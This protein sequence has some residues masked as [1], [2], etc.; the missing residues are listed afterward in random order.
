M[1]RG[2]GTLDQHGNWAF[3]MRAFTKTEKAAKYGLFLL[4]C[5][6]GA[7]YV[8]FIVSFPVVVV[9]LLQQPLFSIL[10]TIGIIFA[11]TVIGYALGILDTRLQDALAQY[12]FAFRFDYIPVFSALIFNWRQSDIDSVKG[13]TVIDQAYES[14]YN[15]GNDGIE[16]IVD[17]TFQVIRNSI[18]VVVVAA[19]LG[20]FNPWLIVIVLAINIAEYGLQRVANRWFARHKAE[21]NQI[22]SYQSYFTRLLLKRSSGKDIRLFNMLPLLHHHLLTLG[23]GVVN[24]QRRYS[25]V[26]TAVGIAQVA[27]NALGML[28]TLLFLIQSQTVSIE[29]IIVFIT[30]MQVLNTRFTTIR[31]AY[32]EIGRNLSYATN[33]RAFLG[34]AQPTERAL[35]LP[36]IGQIRNLQLRDVSFAV[37]DTTLLH[38]ISLNL[39][40][41]HPLAIV[42]EN[43]AGKTTLIKLICGLYTPTSGQ[44]TINDRPRAAWTNASLLERMAV[45]FQDDILLH[46][47]IAENIA[48]VVPRKI[49]YAKVNEVL[50]AVGMADFVQHLPQG[51]QTMLGNELDPNGISLSGGQKEKLLFA[52]VLY[53]DADLNILDEPTAALDPLAEKQFYA[54]AS[55]QLQ[56]KM[57][58]F[59]SHRLGSLTLQSQIMVLKNGRIMGVGT[60]ADLLQSCQYYK[61]LWDAQKSLYAVGEQNEKD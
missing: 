29:N 40:A 30:A 43:G 24:W 36:D 10:I 23:N 32:A 1:K 33:F 17:N 6:V 18:Q 14:I 21:E 49:D 61:K 4:D 2:D 9:R 58:I 51:V 22:T 39:T 38:Y 48:L 35:G 20:Y 41:G 46:F 59:I 57:V 16:A 56:N 44:I 54:L 19:V 47:T 45:E 27:I 26:T 11:V 25:R 31:Q 53:K 8:G 28:G 52:R 7:A 15:G 12:T 50:Q 34:Y 55:Q 13:K 5:L 60:H 3:V 37:S 42:G